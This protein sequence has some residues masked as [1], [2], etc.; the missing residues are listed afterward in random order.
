MQNFDFSSSLPGNDNWTADVIFK[1]K[2]HMHILLLDYTVYTVWRTLPI[3]YIALIQII[4]KFYLIYLYPVSS[5]P[6]K[7]AII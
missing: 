1:D 2:I 3:I 4:V 5:T 6:E 7:I